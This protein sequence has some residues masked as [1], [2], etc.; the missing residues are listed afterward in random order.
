M[1]ISSIS[2]HIYIY[3]FYSVRH[4]KRTAV[5]ASF[6]GFPRGKKP[7][8]L[9]ITI[10][11]KSTF[12][13]TSTHKTALSDLKEHSGA[14]LLQKSGRLLTLASTSHRVCYNVLGLAAIHRSLEMLGLGTY[15]LPEVYLGINVDGITL[16]GS[17]AV[18]ESLRSHERGHFPLRQFL[19]GQSGL[20]EYLALGA[21]FGLWEQVFS[22]DDVGV[23]SILARLGLD[24]LHL[25]EPD[26][27]V[28]Q[29]LDTPFKERLVG[30][31]DMHYVRV[32][33]LGHL[34]SGIDSRPLLRLSFL[35]LEK[36]CALR[37]S[38]C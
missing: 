20:L 23:H 13:K 38:T 26:L 19:A 37:I 32:R 34:K 14:L 17:L 12:S 24:S 16:A 18:A 7:N 27:L 25:R 5:H 1:H 6:H 22:F 30:L 31:E 15:A 8:S 4:S 28:L 10:A 29:K 3:T 9:Y 11:Q 35:A 2:V 33:K 36:Y 21:L